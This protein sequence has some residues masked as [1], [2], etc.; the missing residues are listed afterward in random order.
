MVPT[1]KFK[2]IKALCYTTLYL[3]IVKTKLVVQKNMSNEMAKIYK[4]LS[5]YVFFFTKNP[6]LIQN[7][8]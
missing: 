5:F 7:I 6:N 1:S 2:K 4:K 3:I 8:C